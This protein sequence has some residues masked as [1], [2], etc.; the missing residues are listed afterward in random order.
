M[1]NGVF[2]PR[3]DVP[4][5]SRDRHVAF[6]ARLISFVSSSSLLFEKNYVFNLLLSVKFDI[7][8]LSATWRSI[9]LRSRKE[10]PPKKDRTFVS[11][12]SSRRK[13]ISPKQSPNVSRTIKRTWRS[14]GVIHK[15]IRAVSNASRT[16]VV[17]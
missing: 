10:I 8:Q 2:L 14:T 17:R 13:T 15:T 3:R 12:R 4:A 16:P 1:Y 6:R 7:K 11:K 5:T 9:A